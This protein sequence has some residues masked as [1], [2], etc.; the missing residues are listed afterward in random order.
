MRL[1]KCCGAEIYTKRV[2]LKREVNLS[3]HKTFSSYLEWFCS[4]CH[5]PCKGF[6]VIDSPK[7]R[8]AMKE[9]SNINKESNAVWKLWEKVYDIFSDPDGSQT[10]H[11]AELMEIKKTAIKLVDSLQK[12]AEG[13]DQ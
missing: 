5:K 4:K 12:E 6:V 3:K 13:A 1:S 2:K 7:R 8:K 11:L 9:L 10:T